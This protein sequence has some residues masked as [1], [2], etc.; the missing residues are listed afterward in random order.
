M[1]CQLSGDLMV[2]V[3]L[4]LLRCVQ[5]EEERDRLEGDKLELAGARLQLQL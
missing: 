3:R 1:P 2:T 5:L 4:W